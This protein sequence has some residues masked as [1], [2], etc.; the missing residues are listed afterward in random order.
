M[1][2]PLRV[3]LTPAERAEL[4]EHCRWIREWILRSIHNN[5]T[6]HGG[7]SLSMV[8]MLALLYFRHLRHEP[9]A[10]HDP[11][12]DR[13][14]LSKGH[15]APALYATLSR[16]GYLP[17]QEL[18]TLR[19]LDSRLHGHP[20]AAALPGV[21]ASTGSLGQGISLGV[22]LA[23]AWQYQ[24]QDNRVFCMVGDG[25]LQEGQN[26]EAAMAAAKWGLDRLVVL[27]DRNRLQ[28]DGDTEDIMPLG[29]L[30]GKWRSFGW[31]VLET[32][33]HDLDAVDTALRAALAERGRPT[34][35]IAN[36]VKG[37]GVSYMEGVMHWHHHPVSDEELALALADIG[38]A[39]SQ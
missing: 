38:A 31:H 35:L 18:M 10:P 30:A 37:K 6:G 23:L 4:T 27:V 1:S 26:W 2:E 24:A 19:R 20:H 21:D 25:E 3:P 8:E 33:G 32:D 5:Q 16:A 39:A 28:G 9:R 11:G 7:T 17:P 12:R 14:V 22:G 29:D 36:T 15:G 13:F 34:V